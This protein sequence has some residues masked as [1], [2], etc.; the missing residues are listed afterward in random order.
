MIGTSVVRKEDPALLTEGGRYVADVGP[1]DALHAVFVRSVMAHGVVESIGTDEAK[2]MPG[3]AAVY[4]A[5]DLGLSPEPPGNPLLNQG[6]T[7]T[8]LATDRVRYVGEPY[9]VVLAET[10]AQG[11]DAAEMIWADIEPLDAVVT[12]PDSMAEDVLLFPD[13]G[14]NRSF[15]MPSRAEGDVTDG[16]EL[17]VEL[18]F[19]NPRLSVAPIEPRATVAAWENDHLTVW[20][21][22]QFPHRTRDGFVA[23][24]GIEPE[25]CRVITP[26]VGGG[27]GGKN[28]NYVEDFIVGAAARAIGRPVRWVETRSES[29]TNLSHGRSLDY[30]VALGGTRD[31][32]LQAYRLHI[33]QDAGAYPAIGSVLPMFGRIMASGNYAFDR[34]DASGESVV[35]NT[36]P[37]GAYRGAGRPEATLALER[38]ID[39][40]A[41]EI[42]MDP[43]EL[44]RKNFLRKD[45]FPYVTQTGAEMDTGDY[46]A[47]LD[48]VLEVVNVEALRSEQAARIDDPTR[49]LLGIGW[50]AYVEIT[51]PLGAPEFGSCEIRADGTA[52]LLTGSSA[53][54]QGHDTTFAQ[55]ASELTGISVDKIEVRHGDTNEVKR[56]GGTGGSRSLQVGGTAVWEATQSVVE[57]ARQLAADVLEANPA[58][59]VLDRESGTFSVTGTPALSIGWADVAT[60]AAERNQ[61]LVAEHDFEPPAATFPFGVHCSVVEVDRDTGQVTLLR[62]VAC[63]DAGVIVNPTIVDG[64]VHGG[65]AGGVGQALM[66]EF[67]YDEWG[68]PQTGN[69]MDYAIPAAPEF[70]SFERLAMETPTD[71][72]PLGVKGIGEAGTIGSTPAVQNAVVDALKHL[73]V[74]H[75]DIPVT[76]QRVWRSMHQARQ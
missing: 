49:S 7:R 32:D 2:A 66:E 48:K 75:I 44:R 61:A 38:I 14:T 27:F 60:R 37:V 51:N 11:V 5:T 23:A 40:Y 15:Q 56:G 67:I 30:Q 42:G 6:M 71:R 39:V 20:A 10:L 58:D 68:N 25:Q 4:T 26:D 47:A 19:T 63:D 31:G 54:G 17:V 36:T 72:N 3:V 9:A 69:F 76:P 74:C 53:H 13:L 28:A 46:A 64:Q 24:L 21:C 18:E 55:L 34:V 50:A 65:V 8:W 52:L 29:M 22:T 1:T 16:C 41:A 12:I 45:D 33:M 70:P 35:T 43:A 62:H 59:I 73:G 57:K